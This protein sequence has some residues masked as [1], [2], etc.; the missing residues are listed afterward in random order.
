MRT[1][2]NG[3]TLFMT[4]E[5]EKELD[6][7]FNKIIERYQAIEKNDKKQKEFNE[8]EKKIVKNR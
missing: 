8:A 1:G 5:I 3:T 7:F 4:S 2:D 6:N